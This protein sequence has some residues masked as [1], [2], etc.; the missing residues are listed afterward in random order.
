MKYIKKIVLVNERTYEIFSARATGPIYPQRLVY[1]L[2]AAL[3][4][5]HHPPLLNKVTC[6]ILEN[7]THQHMIY[8]YCCKLAHKKKV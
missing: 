1:K 7:K 5:H 6:R 8:I 3:K 2:Y 4:A